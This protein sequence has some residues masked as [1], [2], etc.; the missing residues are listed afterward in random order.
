MPSRTALAWIAC[1]VFWAAQQAVALARRR[2]VAARGVTN[3]ERARLATSRT[4]AVGYLAGFGAI[5]VVLAV[6]FRVTAWRD[7]LL[8]IHGGFAFQA[9]IFLCYLATG[10][11]VSDL[12]EIAVIAVGSHDGKRVPPGRP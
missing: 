8:P 7:W 12:V 11:A 3:A 9:A 10:C 5:V 4:G 1:V 6:A 2:L